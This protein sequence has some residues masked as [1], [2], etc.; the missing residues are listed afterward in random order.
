M[1]FGMSPAQHK[2]FQVAP[3]WQIYL[4]S[5]SP[6][7]AQ[8]LA[9]LGI[10]FKSV[11]PPYL[12]QPAEAGMDAR[13]YAARCARLKAQ[14]VRL[15]T[16]N[17]RSVIISADTIVVADNMIMGK[18]ADRAAACHML[19]SL[20]GRWHEVYTAVN[21]L[22]PDFEIEICEKTEVHFSDWP[23]DVLAAYVDTDEPFDKAGAYAI[24]GTGAFLAD[25]IN[26]SWS[27]VVGLPLAQV[28]EA[29]LSAHIIEAGS[30][31]S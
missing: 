15:P 16:L 21:I 14:S 30:Y 19:R 10:H 7:R 20:N 27:N 6:R 28:A 9:S 4:A 18:P 25:M 11:A 26:G 5:T 8:L 13:T 23:V 2:V 31:S 12:E 29:L 3:D 17:T 1:C 22:S 24:Q